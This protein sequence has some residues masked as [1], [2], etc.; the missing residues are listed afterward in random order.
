MACRRANM[1]GVIMMNDENVVRS[2]ADGWSQPDAAKFLP[3]FEDDVYY[4]DVA[5][6]RKMP[7]KSHLEEFFTSAHE[8]FSRFVILPSGLISADG[9]IAVEWTMEGTLRDGAA[10]ASGRKPSFSVTGM[11]MLAVSQSGLIARCTDYYNL[12]SIHDQ[13]SGK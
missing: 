5:V 8:M 6:G 4:E 1:S 12:K 13:L 11:S 3:A 2:W 9:K 7:G 10:D